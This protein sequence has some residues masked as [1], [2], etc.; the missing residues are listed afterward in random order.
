MTEREWKTIDSAPKDGM[1]ILIHTKNGFVGEAKWAPKFSE[2]H[3]PVSEAG[4][5]SITLDRR[6]E[7]VAG[8]MPLPLPPPKDEAP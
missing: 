5:Y 4:W 7:N 3:Y 8:W 6:I 2:H 1:H